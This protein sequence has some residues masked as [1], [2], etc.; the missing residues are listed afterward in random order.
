MMKKLF[1]VILTL[2]LV[3][4]VFA[5]GEGTPNMELTAQEGEP[6]NGFLWEN[7]YSEITITGYVGSS[8]DIVIP[9]KING[10]PVTQ[11][12]KDAFDGFAAMKSL[13]IPGS[14][15]IIDNAFS[16]CTGLKNIT[17]SDGLESMESA[18]GGC[19][20]LETIVVPKTVKKMRYAFS[21]CTKL[22]TVNV[23]DG[24]TDLT[25]TFKNCASIETL[26]LPDSYVR[27]FDVSGMKNLKKLTMSEKGLQA[28]LEEIHTATW[29]VETD[30][31]L[32]EYQDLLAQKN[33]L[34]FNSEEQR[35]TLFDQNIGDYTYFFAGE[36]TVDDGIHSVYGEKITEGIKTY[37]NIYFSAYRCD[38]WRFDTNDWCVIKECHTY[39]TVYT[40]F[41]SSYNEDVPDTIEVNG[42]T[43]SVAN[44]VMI[45]YDRPY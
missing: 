12:K 6:A 1:V 3:F 45:G 22:K 20:S 30:T 38:D 4:G 31:S 14:V 21:G 40:F 33:H 5:C 9:S 13:V 44:G 25:N 15:K 29:A 10:K 8:N 34:K 36:E 27:S 42:Q 39:E 7:N 23:P 18:F 17:L 16:D 11:I 19:T 41:A 28:A 32:P 2:C 35:V 43:Y 26:V 37:Q 24:I